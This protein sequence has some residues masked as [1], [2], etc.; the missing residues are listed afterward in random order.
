[1]RKQPLYFQD[2]IRF[3]IGWSSND[4]RFIDYTQPS[5]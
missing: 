4:V 3:E 2:I 5:L 1:M